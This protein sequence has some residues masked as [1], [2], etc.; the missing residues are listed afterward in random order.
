MNTQFDPKMFGDRDYLVTPS[1]LHFEYQEGTVCRYVLVEEIPM[2][3]MNQDHRLKHDEVGKDRKD[4]AKSYLPVKRQTV[5]KQESLGRQLND[6]YVEEYTAK[7][8]KKKA[9]K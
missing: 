4:I 2:N 9:K 8:Q 5:K 7:T 3:E 6:E 1:L